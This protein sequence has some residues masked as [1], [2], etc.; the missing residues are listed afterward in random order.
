MEEEVGGGGRRRRSEEVGGAIT[1]P[2]LPWN[3]LEEE[4]GG[5]TSSLIIGFQLNDFP[6]KNID[7]IDPESLIGLYGILAILR[8]ICQQSFISPT[9]FLLLHRICHDSMTP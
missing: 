2:P 5:V 8:N 3:H 1:Y 7:P 9:I 4:D 6:V